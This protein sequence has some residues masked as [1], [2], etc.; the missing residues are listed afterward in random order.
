M[1]KSIDNLINPKDSLFLIVDLQEKLVPVMAQK[2]QLVNNVVRLVNF[3]N[4]VSIPT[5]YT[6]QKNLGP[7][8]PDIKD[9]LGNI[10]PINKIEFSCFNCLEFA[11]TVKN[12]NRQYL[13]VSG[14]ESHICVT[15]TV[16]QAL[17]NYD[18]HVISDAISSRNIMNSSIAIE[19]MRQNGATISSTEMFIYEIMQKTDTDLFRSVLKLV[20]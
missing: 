17:P 16:L 1:N 12:Y 18:V 2:E 7:T 15:Q 14:I 6:E 13:V 19:R 8:I 20:K 9:L 4:I 3:C 11:K 5:I 10:T